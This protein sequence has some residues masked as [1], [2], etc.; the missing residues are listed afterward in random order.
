MP[1]LLFRAKRKGF[2]TPANSDGT[3]GPIALELDALINEDPDF[4]AEP[5]KSIVE[6]GATV[7]DHVTLRPLKLSLSGVVSNTP[8]GLQSLAQGA[9]FFDNAAQAFKFLK[10]L[11]TNRVPFD[12][13]GG[14]MVYHNMVITSFNAPR[15]KDT[16]NTLTFTMTLEQITIVVS[17]S[18]GAQNFDE[19]VIPTASQTQSNGSQSTTGASAASKAQLKSKLASL[20]DSGVDVFHGLTSGF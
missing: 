18:I 4:T 3:G 13:V 8:V 14:L 10:D 12:F 5:T 7:S 11:F 15:T 6:S 2:V 17:Q 16:A 20:L 9:A 19:A 1:Q